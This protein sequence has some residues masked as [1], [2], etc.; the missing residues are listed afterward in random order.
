MQYVFGHCDLLCGNIIIAKQADD[1]PGE[2]LRIT[3]DQIRFI[4]YEF[5]MSCPAAFDIANHFS[6]WCGFDCDYNLLP[7]RA[8]RER[9]IAQYLA[10]YRRHAN[11]GT[12]DF[13]TAVTALSREVDRFRGIPGLWWAI[14]GF[15]SVLESK[16]KFDWIPYANKRLA[17]YRAWKA[18]FE[19]SRVEKGGEMALREE[20][21]ARE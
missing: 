16:V 6:E 4:D 20:L 9:F 7:G 14:H 19:G 11:I 2:E 15:V 8:V 3:P 12:P 17:E 1:K 5:A 13:E 21:W 10:S 18:E